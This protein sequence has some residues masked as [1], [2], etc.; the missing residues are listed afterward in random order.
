MKKAG[1]AIALLLLLAAAP[2]RADFNAGV[3]AYLQGDYHTAFT[4]MQ[5]L[6]EDAG[7]GYAQYYLGL[8]YLK[9]QGVTEDAKQAGAWFRRAAEQAIP[10]A[11]YRLGELYFEGRGAPKDYEFAYIWYSIGASH[12]HK[13]SVNAIDKAR[14]KLS[15]EERAEADKLIKRY[16]LKYGPR[17]D[18]GSD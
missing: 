13:L 16:T 3:V 4:T 12:Q 14:E 6:A 10:Q 8:M 5:P 2:A 11:Q 15:G 1:P 18:T 17:G 9:G 7:H